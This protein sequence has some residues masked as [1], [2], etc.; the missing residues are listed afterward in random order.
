MTKIQVPKPLVFLI[1]ILG[2]SGLASGSVRTEPV[3]L[4]SG[5]SLFAGQGVAMSP[6]NRGT[7]S[8]SE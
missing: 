1:T 6:D 2:V 8:I 5:G 7:L 4:G 3:M